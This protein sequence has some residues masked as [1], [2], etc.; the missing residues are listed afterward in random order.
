MATSEP[1]ADLERSASRVGSTPAVPTR[2]IMATSTDPSR[3]ILP[4][5]PTRGQLTQRAQKDPPSERTMLLVAI[6]VAVLAMLLV[7]LLGTL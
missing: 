4:L 7:G 5:G 2:P 6:G 1:D 3:E